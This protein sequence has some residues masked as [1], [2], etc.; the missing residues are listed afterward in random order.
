MLRAVAAIMKLRSKKRK[1][2]RKS[3][4]FLLTIFIGTFLCIYGS[5]GFCSFFLAVKGDAW[6]VV[7]VQLFL[8]QGLGKHHK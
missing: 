7:G 3:R 6:H 5:L 2:D 4:F 8:S 1:R